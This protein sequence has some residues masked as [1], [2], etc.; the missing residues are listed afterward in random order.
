MRQLVRDLRVGLLI[1]YRSVCGSFAVSSAI[2][3]V[4]VAGIW[5]YGILFAPQTFTFRL[6]SAALL[7]FSS[8]RNGS[9]SLL[10]SGALLPVLAVVWTAAAV[11]WFTVELVRHQRSM[12]RP[13]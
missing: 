10:L 1:V 12:A 13:A 7:E 3:T 11:V 4:A 2:A 5:L 8:Q 9:Y 6:W